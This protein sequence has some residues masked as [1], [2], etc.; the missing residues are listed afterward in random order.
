[1][2]AAKEETREGAAATSSPASGKEGGPAPP[3]IRPDPGGMRRPYRVGT[4]ILIAALKIWCRARVTGVKNV[5]RTGPCLLLS[6]HASVLDPAIAGGMLKRES[7]F[8]ARPGVYRAPIIGALF[9]YLNTHSI[10]RGG[11]D[12]EAIRTCVAVLEAGWPLMMFPEGTRS[13][14]GSVAKPRG[15]FAMILEHLPDVPCVPVYITGT[16]KALGR[17]MLIPRPVK[18][19]VTYGKPFT[20]AARGEDETRRAYYQR[21]A[22]RLEE[23]WR[24]LGAYSAD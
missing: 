7:H 17:G 18:L 12:R 20:I 1:M 3:A 22:D 10:R 5:P 6:N 24:R 23:E 2:T 16:G 9:R 13:R 8:L 4:W 19:S 11:I 14:D 15:G 21:C